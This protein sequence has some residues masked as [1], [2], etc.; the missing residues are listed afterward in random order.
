MGKR[1]KDRVTEYAKKV[2]AGKVIA[3][4]SV[5]QACQRHLDDLKR[6][7]TKDF[8]FKWDLE[9]S[10]EALD[11]YNELTILEGD[12]AIPLKTRGFQ[13][14]ILGSL[15]GWREKRTNYVRFREAYIQLARQNGKTF[16]T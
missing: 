2:V 7:K 5:I 4:K 3:G 10:E 12:E 15:E 8:K 9:R 1:R 11:L 16:H 13:D 6:S 14:F